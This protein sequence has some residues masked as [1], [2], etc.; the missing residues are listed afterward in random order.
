MR[1]F[2]TWVV[3][4]WMFTLLSGCKLNV[5]I[6]SLYTFHDKQRYYFTSNCRFRGKLGERHLSKRGQ[7]SPGL[8]HRVCISPAAVVLCCS[9]ELPTLEWGLRTIP[10]TLQTL[11]PCLLRDG[12]SPVGL[13]VGFYQLKHRVNSET[14]APGPSRIC[15]HGLF[16]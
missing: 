13:A 16:C 8:P 4:T 5:H 1:Y 7:H 6:Y 10:H 15:G 14:G 2:L 11:L 12:V 9:S 3:G